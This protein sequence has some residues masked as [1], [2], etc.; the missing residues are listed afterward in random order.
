MRTLAIQMHAPNDGDDCAALLDFTPELCGQLR[1]L[2]L[3][4][5]DLLDRHTV[6]R[7]V[8]RQ[9]AVP[10]W[11]PRYC[12]TS[13]FQLEQTESDLW[14]EDYVVSD[15]TPEMFVVADEA[16]PTHQLGRDG[17]II[18]TKR[19][20]SFTMHEKHVDEPF[21]SRTIPHNTFREE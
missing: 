6:A 17:Q 16:A 18:L 9:H 12:W 10:A 20:V 2:Y 13:S 4:C 15:A 1:A 3:E 5:R 19:G 8:F 14:G 21:W 7:I 11:E